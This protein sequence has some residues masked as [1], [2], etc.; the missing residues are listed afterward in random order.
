MTIE[1]N[2]GKKRISQKKKI[3]ARFQK[4]KCIYK[5]ND[6]FML[7]RDMPEMTGNTPMHAGGENFA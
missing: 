6:S 1:V 2:M 7:L 4:N 3:F 5:R